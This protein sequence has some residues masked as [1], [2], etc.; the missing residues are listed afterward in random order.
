MSLKNLDPDKNNV[1]KTLFGE[2]R[3]VLELPRTGLDN[4]LE[5]LA[6][7]G[8]LTPLAYLYKNWASLPARFPTHFG[9]SGLP[10]A[11]GGRESLLILLAVSLILYPLLTVLSYFPHIYNY[12][13]RITEENAERQYR[14]ARSLMLWIKVEML[15]LFGYIQWSSIQ[16]ALGKAAG[17]G[18]AFLPITLAVA[19]GTLA[20]YIWAAWRGR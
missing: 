18:T 8:L 10:D 12:P 11:W 19:F 1:R 16:V 15:W 9:A 4:A 13:W 5:V 6:A 3:P 2:T 20:I 7:A 14:L 17:L